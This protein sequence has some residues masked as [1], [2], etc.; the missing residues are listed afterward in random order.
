MKVKVNNE[1]V[2]VPVFKVNTGVPLAQVQAILGGTDGELVI[3]DGVT[4]LR[5]NALHRYPHIQRVVLPS[6]ITR[7]GN[8]VFQYASIDN[9]VLSPNVTAMGT[10]V[11]AY[12]TFDTV[13]LNC[14]RISLPAYT[15]NWTSVRIVKVNLPNIREIGVGAFASAKDVEE[16][17]FSSYDHVVP[18]A[19]T[20]SFVNIPETCKIIVPAALYDAWTT[21]TNWAT[22]VAQGYNFV[23]R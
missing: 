12:G 15:F 2:D 22:L 17:D 18:L 9:V 10:Y 11:F 14:S 6:S 7:I 5:D 8:S 16:I 1:W 21:A 4:E 13:E 3:P 19:F 20:N 23:A